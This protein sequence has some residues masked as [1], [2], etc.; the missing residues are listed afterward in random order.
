MKW[1]IKPLWRTL[2]FVSTPMLLLILVVVAIAAPWLAPYEPNDTDL[3]NTLA[4]PSA[5]LN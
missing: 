2:A 5:S 3:L 4:A 1:L